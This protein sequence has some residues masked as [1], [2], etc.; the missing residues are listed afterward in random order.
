MKNTG[1]L[2][3]QSEKKYFFPVELHAGAVGRFNA[4]TGVISALPVKVADQ[5][6]EI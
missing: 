5:F 3:Q 2:I 4:C 1:M 6:L